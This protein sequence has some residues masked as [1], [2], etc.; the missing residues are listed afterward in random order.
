LCM[1]VGADLPLL[2]IRKQMVG[3]LD[4]IIQIH[5]FR[6]GKRRI[7]QMSEVTGIQGDTIT[8]QDIF[9]FQTETKDLGLE[10]R[11][12]FKTT[13]MVPSFMERLKYQ[14]IELPSDFF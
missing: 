12:V 3:A 1:L 7:V 13:G 4:L 11:G 14:G 5:R 6:S 9:L 8:M 10:E 2:A